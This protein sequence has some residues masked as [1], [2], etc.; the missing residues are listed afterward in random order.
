MRSMLRAID[1]DQ[2]NLVYDPR[3]DPEAKE[4]TWVEGLEGVFHK[5]ARTGILGEKFDLAKARRYR[6]VRI[7]VWMLDPNLYFQLGRDHR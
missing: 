3:Y 4:Q 6:A 1:M 7:P 2:A 5:V